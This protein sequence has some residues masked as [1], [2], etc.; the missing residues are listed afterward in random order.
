[1]EPERFTAS[2]NIHMTFDNKTKLITYLS[3]NF[4]VWIFSPKTYF[5]DENI[6][7][8]HSTITFINYPSREGWDWKLIWVLSFTTAS[9]NSSFIICNESH[10]LKKLKSNDLD[11][12]KFN[13]FS[14]TVFVEQ[15]FYFHYS[16]LQKM[17]SLWFTYLWC[18]NV[19]LIANDTLSACCAYTLTLMVSI[20]IARLKVDSKSFYKQSVNWLW[21]GGGVWDKKLFLKYAKC[22]WKRRMKEQRKPPA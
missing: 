21:R 9:R 11:L 4:V 19:V 20:R 15:S 5:S 3:W 10:P 14:K 16:R 2:V 6:Q 17:F 1:M 8:L 12:Q 13:F 7:N 18:F 22:E